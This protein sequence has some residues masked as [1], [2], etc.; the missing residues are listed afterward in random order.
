M[1]SMLKC[2]LITL[3][4]QSK[5]Y[6]FLFLKALQDLVEV[7]MSLKHAVEYSYGEVNIN[8]GPL[9]T[10]LTAY[11]DMLAAQGAL[12]AALTYLGKASN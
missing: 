4:I 12:S 5:C 8:S 3:I 1:S 11:A 2:L 7:V 6:S 9:S 10:K